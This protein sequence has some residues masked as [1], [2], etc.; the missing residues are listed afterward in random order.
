MIPIGL[1]WF[2]V[3]G[4]GYLLVLAARIAADPAHPRRWGSASFWFLLGAT[5][6]GGPHVPAEWVGYAVMVL[7]L[8]AA[9]KAVAPP[10]FASGDERHLEARAQVLGN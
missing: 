2:L 1:E 4:G 8:L 6:A 7:A 5:F 9:T 10:R 3:L